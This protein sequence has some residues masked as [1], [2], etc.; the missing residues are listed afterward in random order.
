MTVLIHIIFLMIFSISFVGCTPSSLQNSEFDPTFGSQGKV[1]TDFF[2]AD[3]VVSAITAQSDHKII[4]V[5]YATENQRKHLAISRYLP[6]GTLDL[7]FSEDGKQIHDFLEDSEAVAVHTDA[8]KNILV[9]GRRYSLSTSEIVLVRFSQHGTLDT[10]FGTNGTVIWSLSGAKLYPG[11]LKLTSDGKILV[12]GGNL[13]FTTPCFT[14]ARFLANGN[15]DSSFGNA[16]VATSVMSADEQRIQSIVT[17]AQNRIIVGGF[18]KVGPL[19]DFA[20]ARFSDS[21][22]LDTTFG[23][24]GKRL[25]DFSN[26]LT[27]SDD[28][29]HTLMIDSDQK[30]TA[31]G[32][33]DNS[34][35]R[36]FAVARFTDLGGL[37][38][39]FATQGKK[40]IPFERNGVQFSLSSQAAIETSEGKIYAVGKVNFGTDEDLTITR[41]SSAFELDLI[42]GNLG[43]YAL[44]FFFK[45]DEA[46]AL[47][48]I[49]G[50][51]VVAGST[52]TI[53]GSKDFL[54][55]RLK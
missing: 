37:D 6:G 17:D 49:Q 27:T 41:L 14:L 28:S 2:G 22:V 42:F 12:G 47:Q 54:L 19:G 31:M 44:D 7:T 18:G 9:L 24:S 25:V 29:I 5:G 21:G 10:S 51:V 48:S 50:K 13:N 53:D 45:N 55:L 36:S 43:T 1:I 30:I 16:G 52:E 39:S 20:L 8:K 33:V 32:S 35:Y 11:A 34:I 4:A 23:I 46:R 40:Q 3:D 15:F 26:G 38:V